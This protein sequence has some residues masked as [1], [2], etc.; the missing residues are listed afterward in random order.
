MGDV[1]LPIGSVEAG[2]NQLRHRGGISDLLSLH[3]G[4]RLR[5]QVSPC[6]AAKQRR[7][8]RRTPAA[9]ETKRL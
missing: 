1:W 5:V 7:R 6:V 4:G 9:S 2:S 8:T 3:P